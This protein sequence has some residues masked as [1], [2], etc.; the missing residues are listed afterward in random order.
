MYS[1]DEEEEK[2]RENVKIYKRKSEQILNYLEA[3]CSPVINFSKA[4]E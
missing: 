3:W 4:P 2:K 1:I